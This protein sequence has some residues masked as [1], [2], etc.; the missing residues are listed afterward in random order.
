MP[1]TIYISFFLSQS[2]DNDLKLWPT[3]FKLTPPHWCTPAQ[4]LCLPLSQVTGVSETSPLYLVIRSPWVPHE[5]HLLL[6]RERQWGK[7]LQPNHCFHPRDREPWPSPNI[8]P[9]RF[10]TSRMHICPEDKSFLLLSQKPL[11]VWWHWCKELIFTLGNEFNS[12]RPLVSLVLRTPSLDWMVHKVP[13]RVF[14]WLSI[15]FYNTNCG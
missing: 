6:W 1:Y 8:T 5:Q 11:F 13:K 12:F 3:F 9:K 2:T 14:G 15:F 10:T 4:V 7:L